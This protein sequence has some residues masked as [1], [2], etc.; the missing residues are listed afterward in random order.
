MKNTG[1]TRSLDSLYRI[2]IPKEM[3]ISM[4]IELGD[5][6]EFFIDQETGFLGIQ[7]YVDTSCKLCSSAEQLTYFR[8]SLLCKNCIT[9]LKE[10][11]GVSRIPVPVVKKHTYVEKRIY[12]SSLK[13]IRQLKELMLQYPDAKQHDYAKWLGTSQSRASKL[14]KLII[15]LR[16]ID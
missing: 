6:L 7:K 9:E 10:N 1:M 12:H 2:V 15:N 5:F 14:K 13:M 8:D 3:R 16:L 11:I 4:G